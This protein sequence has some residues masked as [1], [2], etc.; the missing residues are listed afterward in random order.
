MTEYLT[1]HCVHNNNEKYMNR[2][3]KLYT[4]EEINW[5]KNKQYD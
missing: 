4:N 1:S 2:K 3:C 5:K